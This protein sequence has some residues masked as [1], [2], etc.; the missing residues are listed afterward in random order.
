MKTSKEN[1]VAWGDCGIYEWLPTPGEPV[2]TM[3]PLVR[4]EQG[5]RF[6]SAQN[7]QT[8]AAPVEAVHHPPHADGGIV[9]TGFW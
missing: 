3:P 4:R 5:I 8:I 7:S 9:G 1:P 2:P 6:Y